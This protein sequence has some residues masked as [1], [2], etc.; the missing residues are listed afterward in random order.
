MSITPEARAQIIL[1]AVNAV[2]PDDGSSDTPWATQV[3]S[4]AADIY[5]LAYGERS[6]AVKAITG[7]ENSKVFTAT[8]LDVT[9]EQSSTRGLVKLKTA[10][11][12]F[13]EDGIEVARTE[14][15]DDPSGRAMARALRAIKGHRIVIWVEV[16]EI[17]GGASKVR[18]IRHFEDLGPDTSED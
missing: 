15:T 6:A 11:S 3:A 10:P 2:G 14:R 13:H 12:K 16:E 4:K 17:N 18:V 5:V 8:V 1:A 7:I 9:K